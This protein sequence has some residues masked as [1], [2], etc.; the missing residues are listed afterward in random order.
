[1]K[2]KKKKQLWD[3]I[4]RGWDLDRTKKNDRIIASELFRMYFR[5]INS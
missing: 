1:M 5:H 3:L 2:T 4:I